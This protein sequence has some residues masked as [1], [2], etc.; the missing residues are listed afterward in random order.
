MDIN[1]GDIAWPE[2]LFKGIE[3]MRKN[4]K[5]KIKIKKKYGFGRVQN[6]DKLRFP[7]GYEEEGSEKRQ[8]LISKGVIYEVKLL[9]WIERVDI[10][11]DG[12]F[13]KTFS[14]KPKK[15]EWETPSE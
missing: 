14:E 13:L 4:E 2:G 10:E 1:L 9:D 11:A 7:P 12:N 8:R 15:G 6:M 3:E 5:A